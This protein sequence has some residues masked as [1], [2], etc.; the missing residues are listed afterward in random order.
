MVYHFFKKLFCGINCKVY[1]LFDRYILKE[2]F[3]PFVVGLI[4]YTFVL[5]MNEILVMSELFIERDVPLQVVLVLFIYLIPSILAISL[6]MSALLGIL[7]G[8]SRMSSD[9]EITALKTLGVSYKRLVRPLLFFALCIW[10]LTSYL[11]LYTAPHANHQWM[12]TLYNSVLSKVQLNINPREFNETIPNTM[13]FVQD[14]TQDNTWKNIIVYL[15]EPVDEPKLLYAK[16]GRINIY[17]EQKSAY[18]E[19]FDGVQHSYALSN[20]EDFYSVFS[21]ESLQKNVEVGSFF[22]NFSETDKSVREKDIDELRAD[23]HVIQEELDQFGPEEVDSVEYRQKKR[24]HTSHEIEI[25]KKISIPFAC[26][27]FALLGLPLG[28]ST[29]KG[30]RTSGFTISIGIIIIYYVLITAG[31]QLAKDGEIS[32]VFGMWAPNIFFGLL[33]IVIFV[34]SLRESFRWPIFS[35]SLFKR[36]DKRL[37]RLKTRPV[38]TKRLRYLI[39]FPNILD[40]YIIRKFLTLFLLIFFSLIL[41]FVIITFFE[42]IDDVYQHNKT[43]GQFLVYIWFRIPEFI[44]YTLPICAMASSLLCIGFLTKTNE[45]TAM[46]TIGISVYRIISPIVVLSFL[47]CVVSFY[48]QENIT[49]YT[50]KKAEEKW[51][52]I[53]DIPPRSYNQ[54]DQRWVMGRDRNRF[55]Y[56]KHFDPDIPAFSSLSI[57]EFDPD[58]WSLNKRYFAEKGYFLEGKL[59]LVDCWFRDFLDNKPVNFERR[60]SLE[61]FDAE[62]QQYFVKVW[63]DSDQLNYGELSAYIDDV[64]AKGFETVQYKVDLN[65]KVSFPLAGL[66]MTLLGIPFAFSM[67]KRGT[68]VGVGLSLLFAMI[69]WGAMGVFKSLGYIHFLSPFLAAWG[70]NLFFGLIGLYLLFNLRT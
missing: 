66:V 27:I 37:S 17:P 9:F 47:V 19:L 46:K 11:S 1:K 31:E 25:Q 52:E 28:A 44:H 48:L 42:Q 62:D 8:L 56:Y 18:L 41:V 60:D 10:I 22:P 43:I 68:L 39:R 40:R 32:A 15:N 67:G 2:I 35:M 29:K 65:Y 51:N 54:L 13:L 53:N 16:T 21:F 36:K 58:S 55:Y 45:I 57:Y 50:N 61:L 38:R 64:E 26:F 20:P 7:S 33:A 59:I 24:I 5:L 34:I 69:Y 12:L 70:P 30:G 63:K 3:S 49:P 6:P 14:V 4:A 23:V